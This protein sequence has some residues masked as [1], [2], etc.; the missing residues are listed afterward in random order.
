MKPPP[1]TYHRARDVQGAADLVA[2]LGEDAKFLAG[3]QSLIPM[4]NFRLARPEHLID[5]G[6]LRELSFVDARADSLRVGSLSTHRAVETA[7]LGAGFAVVRDTMRW[8]GHLPI[9]ARGTVGGSLAH[10][11]AT[12]EWCLLA[13]L[14][15]A[16]I[17]VA[18]SG[19]RRRTIAAREAFLGFYTTVLEEDELI[20]EVLF[21]RPA[22]HAA[23][24]EFA[25]RK[26]D[27]ALVSAAVDLDLGA[28]TVSGGRVAL[29]G[30]GPAVTRVPE[31]EQVLQ[32][33][34]RAG[35]ELF[36]ECAHAAAAAVEPPEDGDAG[37]EY[38]KALVR[39]LVIHA[40]EEAVAR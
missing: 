22:P 21:G 8:I 28:G 16:D 18:G 14:L 35:R 20:V 11:D 30:V 23:V 13:V 24:T 10:A 40:C 6:R 25:E 3:G 9:R 7:D 39:N 36:E 15:D 37:T 5:I 4:M 2:E 19:G 1:F 33:G 17:V 12:A 31:A 38:R 32:A 34:G 26:G 29:G 27:F